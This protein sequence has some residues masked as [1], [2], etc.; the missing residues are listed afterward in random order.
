MRMV[1][2][3]AGAVGVGHGRKQEVLDTSRDKGFVIL[4]SHILLY[5]SPCMNLWRPLSRIQY[6]GRRFI[7]Q[8]LPSSE[9]PLKLFTRRLNWLLRH[10]AVPPVMTLRPDGFVRL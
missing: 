7:S 8:N 4:H 6:S 1:V 10:G 5:A 2:G 9:D 3:L